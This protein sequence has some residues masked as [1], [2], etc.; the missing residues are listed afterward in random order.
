MSAQP[1]YRHWFG[2]AYQILY[3]HRDAL[4]AQR[5]I[6]FL[7]RATL[8]RPEWKILDIGCGHGRHLQAFWKQGFHHTVGI[9]LSTAQL[10]DARKQSLAV[11]RADMRMLPFPLGHFDLIASLFT[12]F[13]YFATSDEDLKTL[14]GFVACLRP[15]G[16]LFLDLPNKHHILQNLV[17]V[18]ERMVDGMVIVQR[19]RVECHADGEQVV[20]TIEIR[21]ASG[22][23]QFFEERV[24]LW[25]LAP[26]QMAAEQ[27]GFQLQ[28]VIGDECGESYNPNTSQR[29]ALLLRRKP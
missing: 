10:A 25:E 3:P 4:Q 21:A 16:F 12:S 17:A 1:W 20:K 14:A 26:L 22:H 13:G 6:R 2:E 24:R 29:M 28:Q 23:T 7:T 8:A 15:Q 27:M 5:Q 11:A 19:R 18:D 9:D